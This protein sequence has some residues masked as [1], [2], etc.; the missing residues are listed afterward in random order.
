MSRV[1]LSA[2][3]ALALLTGC[4]TKVKKLK[5]AGLD[6]HKKGNYELCVKS[7]QESIA[8][9]EPIARDPGASPNHREVAEFGVSYVY[10]FLADCLDK[11]GRRREAMAALEK[12]VTYYTAQCARGPAFLEGAMWTAACERNADA[13]ETLAKW[14]KEARR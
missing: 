2:L 7:F 12:S 14:K 9:E 4:A 3:A 8:V 1:S 13:V 10:N 5:I 6:A 11:L